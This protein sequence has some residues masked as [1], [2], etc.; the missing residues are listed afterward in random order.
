M[1]FAD[2]SPEEQ[3]ERGVPTLQDEGF[4]YFEGKI[5]PMSEAKVSIATHALQYGTGCFEGIRG[6]YNEKHGRLY[7]LLM[8]E[9]YERMAD[10]MRLLRMDIKETV[11]DLCRITVDLVRRHGYHQD[12]YIRP[13]AYK[14]ECT[15]RVGLSG[16]KDGLAI[17]AFPMGNYVDISDGLSVCTSSWRRANSN[18]MPVRA[19]VTG[20]YVNSALAV[21]DA[22]EAG[23]DEAIMLTHDGYISEASSCNI[24]VL[25]GG[26]LATPAVSEDILEGITRNALIELIQ[27]EFQ[28]PIEQRRID[29]TELY[30]ADEIFTCG[31]GVQV[32]PVT[33]VDHRPIGTGRPGTF[34]MELQQAYLAACRGENE[35][36]IHWVTPV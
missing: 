14:S 32:S 15:I 13:F 7:I 5:V 10:S 26:K 19:K 34:T 29:R 36:Y 30:A 27:N 4:A 21:S 3:K 12:V 2:V 23:F 16:I 18:A 17:Y 35:R 22:K 31:T 1:S 33:H 6:Y 11:D 24:F 25:R 20:V 9:H 8:R 28:I